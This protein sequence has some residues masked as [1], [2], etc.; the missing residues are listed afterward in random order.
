[1]CFKNSLAETYSKSQLHRIHCITQKRLTAPCS[2]P[3]LNPQQNKTQKPIV[4]FKNT[5]AETNNKSQLYRIH[6]I[7][8]KRLTLHPA[9]GKPP[10]HTHCTMN[11]T[12]IIQE[13]SSSLNTVERFT[14][15][16]TN[17]N[18]SIQKI[19]NVRRN[20]YRVLRLRSDQWCRNVQLVSKAPAECKNSVL[21]EIFE[22]FKWS[23]S[24]NGGRVFS[25]FEKSQIKSV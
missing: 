19:R 16:S 7:T 10:V 13:L 6:C 22:N 5:L 8:K 15:K 23:W 24:Q 21:D 12:P 11:Y 20:R 2:R 1:V 18:N 25:C 3:L 4:C 9:V 17:N 14:Q